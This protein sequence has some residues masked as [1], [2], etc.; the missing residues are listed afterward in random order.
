MNAHMPGPLI[1]PYEGVTPSFASPFVYAGPGSSVLGRATIGK[2]AW[3]GL[4][5]VIRADGHYVR[6]GDDF[7]LGA[8]STVH[9]A[10][11]VFPCVIGDRVSVGENSCVHACTVGSDVIIG[12]N[13]VVLDG[14][15]VEDHVVIV[16]GTTVFPGKRIPSGHVY[17]GNPAKPLLALSASDFAQHRQR[18]LA[19]RNDAERRPPGRSRPAEGSRIDPSAFIP[20]TASIRGRLEAA[21][22]TSIWFSN[23]FDA[24]EATITIGQNSNVQDNTVIRCGTAQGVTIGQNTTVG[25]NVYMNDCVIGEEAL[26]GI[27]SHVARGTVIE[28]RVLLAA[29]ART[30]EGQMLKS[31]WLYGRAP[32]RQIAPLDKAKYEMIGYIIGHYCQYARDYAAA[33]REFEASLR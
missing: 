2:A 31:G 12:D 18:A 4:L 8:R 17:G 1:L 24:G 32:A 30:E 6:I 11:D 16:S 7:T 9:I 28:D 25:H 13:A 3:L 23:D 19:A 26:I 14:A 20:S 5:S 33:E 15:V 29:G 21:S 10:H 27:G 22:N